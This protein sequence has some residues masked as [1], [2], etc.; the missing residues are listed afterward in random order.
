MDDTTM[1]STP[2]TM[3]TQFNIHEKLNL[4]GFTMHSHMMHGNCNQALNTR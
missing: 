3:M 2:T 1:S 4:L